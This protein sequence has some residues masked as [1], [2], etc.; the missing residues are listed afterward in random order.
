MVPGLS[1][2]DLIRRYVDGFNARR[3]GDVAELF[4]TD[5][6]FA[7]IDFADPKPAR[8]G[9][10]EFVERWAGA[11]LHSRLRIEH[12]EPRGASLVEVDLLATGTHIGTLDM[13]MYHFEPTQVKVALPVRQL[14]EFTD[15]QI[16]Y[17]SISVDLQQLVRQLTTLN[18]SALDSHLE[19]IGRLRSELAGQAEEGR[20]R[21]LAERLGRELD[22]ARR[23]LRPY[24]R[25]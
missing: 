7:W 8:E 9:F 5:A 23:I 14:F 2:D 22:A 18:V 24:Y 11:F 17:T 20:V 16:A 3:F 4:G 19:E 15:A 1:A 12:V 13:R 6:R 21:E 25:R 10:R